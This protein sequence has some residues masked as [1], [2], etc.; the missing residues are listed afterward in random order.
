MSKRE[1]GVLPES[2]QG[3]Y[4]YPLPSP[5][6]EQQAADLASGFAALAD[7]ARLRLFTLIAS[8]P[9]RV[10]ACSLVEPVGRSQPTVSHH[11]KVLYEAG[12]VDKERRG[13]WIWYWAVPGQVDELM[14]AL[15][16]PAEAPA[17]GR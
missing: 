1:L 12:L 5:L 17:S 4:P 8:Q 3:C 10:C 16:L 15:G 11:L 9:G 7:P 2:D 6:D 13:S 14:S